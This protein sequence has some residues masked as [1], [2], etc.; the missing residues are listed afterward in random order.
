MPKICINHQESPFL[1]EMSDDE[2]FLLASITL[3]TKASPGDTEAWEGLLEQVKGREL[4]LL[5]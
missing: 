5:E 1:I 4:S 2:D 3:S